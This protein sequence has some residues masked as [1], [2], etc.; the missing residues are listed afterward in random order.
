VNVAHD[1]FEQ[2]AEVIRF[3]RRARDFAHHLHQLRASPHLIAPA[4]IGDRTGDLIGDSSEERN[5]IVERAKARALQIEDGPRAL[6]REARERTAPASFPAS[7]RRNRDR[8]ERRRAE[9]ASRS[10]LRFR[11]HHCRADGCS[12]QSAIRPRSE[13]TAQWKTSLLLEIANTPGSLYRALGVFATANIDLSKI[14]SR[15]IPGKPRDYAFYLDVI[16]NLA[17]TSIAQAI[18]QL[19]ADAD[20]VTVLGCYARAGEDSSILERRH[21]QQHVM[22]SGAVV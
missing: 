5:L 14:E 1:A 17:D 7:S 9:S 22:R 8:C 2:I 20:S 3:Q 6:C 19:R 18:E 10:K 16:G 4:G 21:R 13:P 12:Q 15:P 11:P